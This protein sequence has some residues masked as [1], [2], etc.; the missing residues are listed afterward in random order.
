MF[1][2]FN[3]ILISRNDKIQKS[4]PKKDRQTHDHVGKIGN[5]LDHYYIFYDFLN[6]H[7]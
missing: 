7:A 4:E 6:E 1:K 3:T 2:Q 5:D